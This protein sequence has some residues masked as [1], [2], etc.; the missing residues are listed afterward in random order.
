M[1]TQIIDLG[2]GQ[3]DD[4]LLPHDYLRRAAAA[5]LGW[6]RPDVLQYA[7]EEGV[8]SLR[9]ALAEFLTR[10]Y[11]R[12]VSPDELLLTCGA[13]HG[14]D[15]TVSRYAPPGSTVVVEAPTYFLGLEVLRSR[16]LRLA[17]VPIDQDGLDVDSLGDVLASSAA[18]LVYTI[19]TFHNP[20]GATL[21]DER[22]RRL[23]L[24]AAEYGVRVVADEVYHLAVPFNEAP[25][26][27]RAG[28]DEHVL[29]L[30]SFSKILAP[31][32]RL[33]WLECSPGVVT[34]LRADAVLRSAGGANPMA[35]AVVEAALRLGLQDTFLEELW[36]AYRRRR[37]H[38]IAAVSSLLPEVDFL[39]PAG[40]YYLWLK[41]PFSLDA[42]AVLPMARQAGVSFLCG[43]AFAAD[44]GFQDCLRVCFT[45]YDEAR[46]A[47]GIERLARVLQPLMTSRRHAGHSPRND[48]C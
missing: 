34:V 8:G 43:P 30:G 47:D 31:G 46:F 36:G 41:L 33:G 22:R 9:D 23:T 3:I 32:L 24:L 4:A 10:Q 5:I 19:P 45:Y 2:I 13:T 28:G 14:L 37:L 27:L 44:G 38:A 21:S 1:P 42:D 25:Q 12:P 17:S 48:G 40:G 6:R 16:G 35:G 15:L 18:S 11:G 39:H 7:P 20:T 26:S 29:S